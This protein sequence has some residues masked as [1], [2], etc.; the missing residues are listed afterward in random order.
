MPTNR[1]GDPGDFGKTQAAGGEGAAHDGR[2]TEIAVD[3]ARED[4][5]DPA[6][7]D[8]ER[9]RMRDLLRASEAQFR[10][11]AEA[12]S[13][14]LWV[15][16]AE[17][18]Q[19][20]FLSP[21]FNSVYGISRDVAAPGDDLAQWVELI[22]PEDREQALD[23]ISRARAGQSV[24]FEYRISRDGQIRWLRSNV[25]PMLDK[26]GRV[27]RIGGIGR[28]VTELKAALEHQRGLLAELQHQ[29]RNTLAMIRSIVRR[30]ADF[31]ETVDEFAGHL[32]GRIA[33]FSR[34]EVALTRD[35]LAGFDLAELI[36][37]E[38]RAC[39]AREGKQFALHGP[40]VRLKPKA[41]KGIG[42][43]IHELAT[44][45][46]KHGAFTVADG[47]IEVRWSKE[48]RDG[49]PW[50]AFCWTE[51]GMTG[52]PVK[53]VREGFGTILLQQ[54]LQYDL[55]AIVVRRFEPTGFRCEIGLPFAANASG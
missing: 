20:E 7:A 23:G 40:A 27:Q 11:F 55:G 22:V 34:V 46:V 43:A 52:R 16:D 4:C 8:P 29:V 48:E 3:P 26:H 37:D 28:D 18:L 12:S 1:P 45:A 13:D 2:S 6:G 30:T 38:L 49:E 41:A 25:F 10:Q 35:P 47:H 36:S 32:E 51:S 15:R 50:L 31:S 9:E 53:Q 24:N 17:S 39:A 21:A 5:F 42:L 44:N 14:V 19:W 33:A 54:T